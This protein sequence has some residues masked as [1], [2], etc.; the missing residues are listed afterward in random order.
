MSARLIHTTPIVGAT[1]VCFAALSAAAPDRR[2]TALKTPAPSVEIVRLDVDGDGKPD[3]LERWWNGKRV[4]WLDEN[5]DMKAGDTRG[6][7]VG[8]AVQVDIDGDGLY[9]GPGDWNIKWVDTDGDGQ[10][11]VQAFAF[12]KPTAQGVAGHGAHWMLFIDVEKDGVLGWVDWD[13]FKFD[14]WA[15]TGTGAWLPDYN[16]ESIFLKIHSDPHK[17]EDLTLNWENPFSFYDPDGDGVSEMAIRW[18]DPPSNG[19]GITRLSGRLTEAYASLDL[20]NDTARDNETDFDISFRVNGGPG[21]AYRDFKHPLPRFAGAPKFDAFFASNDWRRVDSVSYM[22]HD[23]GWGYLF[24]GDWANRYMVV[25]EDDDDHRWERVE[26]YYPTHGRGTEDSR[27]D[28]YSTKRW[29][30]DTWVRDWQVTE[31]TSP[32][33]SG[34]PQADSLGDRGEFDADDSGRG[35]LYVGVFDRKMHLAGAEWGAWTVDHDGR[36]HGGW[37]TPS[38][39]ENAPAVEEVVRYRDTDANGFLDT[40]QYDYDGDR[41]IDFTVSLLDYKTPAEPHPD[42]VALIDA[43]AAGWQGLH[44]AYEEIAAS[45]WREALS[46][47]RAAWRRGLTTPE[48]DRLANGG[49]LSQRYDSGYWIK[50]KVFRLLRARID[51]ARRDEPKSAAGLTD[52]EARLKRTYYTGHFDDYVKEIG[53][54]PGR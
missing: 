9:D 31:G 41:T 19:D 34:H 38:R 22:P 35:K 7:Q 30:R 10:A 45:S 4:R 2:R 8:D 5:G 16:G 36:Y 23:K 50:E 39:K 27:V 18:L 3:V 28:V 48:L 52:L 33:V 46:V 11:D 14:C 21:I 49:S 1:L 42:A 51:E 12:S 32:G 54:V 13:S 44:K 24:G 37:N 26:M 29:A 25:D 20:D 40:V 6:D 53:N 15:Y 17:I 47:Y 43:E